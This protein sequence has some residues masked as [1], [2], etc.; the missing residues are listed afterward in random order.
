MNGNTSTNGY[1]KDVSTS[2]KYY[3]GF[4]IIK[5]EKTLYGWIGMKRATATWSFSFYL[6][7]YAIL[8]EYEE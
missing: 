4:K 2:N 3:I 1:W 5:D 6:T 7:D 8:K